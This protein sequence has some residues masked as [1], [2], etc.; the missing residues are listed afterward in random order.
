M[1]RAALRRKALRQPGGYALL[2]PPRAP[3]TIE[4]LF[5]AV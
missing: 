5:P 4:N 1:K 2:F 3:K